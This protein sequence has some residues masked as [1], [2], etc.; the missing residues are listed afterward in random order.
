MF[1]KKNN[2]RNYVLVLFIILATI[3]FIICTYLNKE[4]NIILITFFQLIKFFKPHDGKKM[5]QKLPEVIII[6]SS[7]SGF[8]IFIMQR[9][10]FLNPFI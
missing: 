3:Y 8:I 7:K 9:N 5:V 6:G 4:L 2:I 1:Y 10:I